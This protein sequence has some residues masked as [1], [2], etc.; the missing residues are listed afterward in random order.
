M[1]AQTR[2]QSIRKRS[3]PSDEIV[4][5]HG[6][7]KRK[8]YEERQFPVLSKEEYDAKYEKTRLM[9]R[10]I[11]EEEEEMKNSRK[12]I[13][14]EE[15]ISKEI[16]TK[17]RKKIQKIVSYI[18]ENY[19]CNIFRNMDIYYKAKEQNNKKRLETMS[20][21]YNVD[22]GKLHNIDGNFSKTKD[23]ELDKVLD[24]LSKLYL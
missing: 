13:V 1:V 10:K 11:R 8:V 3:R 18:E 17:S 6:K 21:Q 4:V 19:L 5:S 7:V 16:D 14:L 22:L 9:L 20:R 23:K 12:I 2:L 15:I 24:R